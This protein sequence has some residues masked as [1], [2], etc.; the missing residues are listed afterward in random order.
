MGK[1]R[2]YI[3]HLNTITAH[4]Q[5][6]GVLKIL[7]D[8]EDIIVKYNQSQLLEGKT[9]KGEFLREYR[10]QQYRS[11]KLRLNPKGV[12]DLRVSGSLY[13]HMFIRAQQFP[14]SIFSHD[15][16]AE[17]LTEDY[18]DD[19]FGVSKESK[20]SLNIEFLKEEIQKYYRK[21]LRVR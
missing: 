14:V 12:T 7:R 20:K 19:I 16:K 2:N 8:N 17:K 4:E 1:L 3:A 10:N 11:F 5:E 9:Y 21:L 18:S 6:E 13:D 15:R